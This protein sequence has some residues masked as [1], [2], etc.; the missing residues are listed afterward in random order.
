MNGVFGVKVIS[1]MPMWKRMRDVFEKFHHWNILV[2]TLSVKSIGE[3]EDDSTFLF[4]KS[5]SNW[6]SKSK[7]KNTFI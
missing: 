7:V 2:G 5:K 4:P 3:G 6:N 1:V